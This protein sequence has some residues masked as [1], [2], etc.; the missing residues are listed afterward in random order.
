MSK[1]VSE[2][3]A[4]DLGDVIAPPIRASNLTRSIFHLASALFALALLHLLPS[5]AWLIGVSAAFAISAWTMEIARRRS[6]AVNDRLMALFSP[7]AHPHE[8]H[9]VNSSTWYVSALLMLA[10]AAPRPAAEV[11]V[12]VLGVADPVAGLVGRR[13]GRTRLVAGRSLE[14]ST[15]F[16]VAGALVAGG[17]LAATTALPLP[18]LA[19]VAFAGALVGA[20]AELGS[21]RLDDNFTIPLSVTA[22]VAIAEKLMGA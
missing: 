9:R 18:S 4:I 21:T 6:P 15:G 22:A 17:W 20:L 14:G 8:R 2:V 7:V 3:P 13:F 11:G 19:V 1:S 16:V 5:R 12:L 10:I